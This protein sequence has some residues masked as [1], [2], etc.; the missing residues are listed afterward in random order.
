MRE[1]ELLAPIFA[2]RLEGRWEP[3]LEKM[4]DFWSSVLLATGR[5]RGDAVETHRRIAGIE[6]AHFDRWIA[7]FEETALATL[8]TSIAVDVVGRSHNM[9]VTLER[10]ACPGERL[11]G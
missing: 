5:F 2:S 11:P 3:H 10:A 8:P 6:P 9:R 4:C 1:D 7:L